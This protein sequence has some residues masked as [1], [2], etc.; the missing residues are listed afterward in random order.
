MS[1]ASEAYQALAAAMETTV[2]NCQG[3]EL[4]TADN[5]ENPDIAELARICDTCPLFNLCDDYAHIERPKAGIWA[6]KRYRNYSKKET[7]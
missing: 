2:P 1:R 4:F 3:I 5:L 6:G 7:H